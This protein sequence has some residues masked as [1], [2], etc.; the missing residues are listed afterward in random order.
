MSKKLKG[1]PSGG[2][3]NQS[4]VR[5]MGRGG[6]GNQ[7][8]SYAPTPSQ[9]HSGGKYIVSDKDVNNPGWCGCCECTQNVP[10]CDHPSC[11]D[12]GPCFE[13]D[14]FGCMCCRHQSDIE[15]VLAEKGGQFKAQILKTGPAS[16]TNKKLKRSQPAAIVPLRQPHRVLSLDKSKIK[17]GKHIRKKPPRRNDQEMREGGY[18]REERLPIEYDL[19]TIDSGC[20]TP[21]TPYGCPQYYRCI[22]GQCVYQ[23]GNLRREH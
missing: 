15:G 4:S 22:N 10:D 20:I 21:Q 1:G 2:R 7:N 19:Y 5:K 17:Y 12:T 6:R 3:L 14:D 9:F 16:T 18:T 23:I 8:L 11:T 13:T